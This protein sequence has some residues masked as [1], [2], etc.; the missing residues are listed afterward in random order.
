MNEE[1]LAP[2]STCVSF[3]FATILHLIKYSTKNGLISTTYHVNG[4]CVHAQENLVAL[5]FFHMVYSQEGFYALI[6]SLK[7]NNW[8]MKYSFK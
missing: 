5:Y 8:I 2:Y 3:W 7:N 1:V 6:F 4:V